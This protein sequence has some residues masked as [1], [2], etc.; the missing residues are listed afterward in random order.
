[1]RGT[2]SKLMILGGERNQ[3]EQ[4]MWSK[5]V[6][7]VPPWPLLQFLPW[8]PTLHRLCLKICKPNK[9]FPSSVAFGHVVLLQQ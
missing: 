7:S 6:S 8:L 3:V 9:P 2:T 4:A 1:V 5:L